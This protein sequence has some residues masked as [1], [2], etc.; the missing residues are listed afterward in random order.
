[1]SNLLNIGLHV[2]PVNRI[3]SIEPRSDGSWM[4]YLDEEYKKHYRVSSQLVEGKYIIPFLKANG[5][6]DRNYHL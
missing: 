4:V 6:D 1:M 2:I 5:I 3:V